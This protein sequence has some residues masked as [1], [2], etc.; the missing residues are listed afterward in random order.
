MKIQKAKWMLI[1]KT[2]CLFITLYWM[3]FCFGYFG[4]FLGIGTHLCFCLFPRKPQCFPCRSSPS[5]RAEPPTIVSPKFFLWQVW[6]KMVMNLCEWQA[7]DWT[8]VNPLTNPWFSKSCS[9][10]IKSNCSLG[11][12]YD[13]N[14]EKQPI[15]WRT[16]NCRSSINIYLKCNATIKSRTKNAGWMTNSI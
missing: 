11:A 10:V 16:W 8:L 12:Y 6:L 15:S 2:A 7:F 14:V 4:V 1:D 9:A 13:R 5:R 3:L